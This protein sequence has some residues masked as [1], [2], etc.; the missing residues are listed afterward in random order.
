VNIPE[1]E[2]RPISVEWCSVIFSP[3]VAEREETG[4]PV[5]GVVSRH[6][7]GGMSLAADGTDIRTPV[8]KTASRRRMRQV[9]RLTRCPEGFARRCVQTGTAVMRPGVGW[10]IRL[11][12]TPVGACSTILPPYM[13]ATS[14]AWLAAMARSWVT[15]MMAMP[16]LQ[17][18]ERLRISA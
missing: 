5:I 18:V 3:S 9:R 16:G 8:R 13:T 7:N 14:S 12:S 4:Q 11:N 1:F 6:V 10:R 17:P 15:R 2:N